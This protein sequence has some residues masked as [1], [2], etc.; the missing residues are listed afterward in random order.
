MKKDEGKIDGKPAPC[1]ILIVDDEET[2][3][4][5]MKSL[6]ERKGFEVL[7]APTGEQALY[8]LDRLKFDL[9]L[10]DLVLGGIDGLSVLAYSKKVSQDTEVVVITGYASVDSAIQATRKGAFHYLQKPIRSDEL[11]HIVE[12]ALE[13]SRLKTR[14][15]E[16]EQEGAFHSPDI[17]GNS[18]KIQAIKS[19]IDRMKQSEANVLIVGESGTGKELIA[20]AIHNHSRRRD[21][22]FL[23][24]NCAS[25]ADELLANELFGHEKDAYTGASKTTPGLLESAD[26]GTVFFDEVGDMSPTM[27]AKILRVV[28]EKEL[29][30]V[31]SSSPIPVDIRI[32][33]ATNKDLKKLVEAGIFRQD[34]YFR[35]NVIAIQLPTLEQRKE[36]IPLLGM[37]CLKKA[38]GR[39][40]KHFDGFSEEAMGLLMNYSFPGN[41]REL[42]NIVERAAALAP[43]SRIEA[44][45]LPSDLRAFETVAFRKEKGMMKT[46]SEIQQD[47]IQWVLS[48]VG[49]NKTHAAKIL[50]IDRVSLYRKL[51]QQE[52]EE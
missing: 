23:A 17:I 15:R 22:R 9:V 5:R 14:V 28:Q 33:S 20:R 42:E 34:L 11:Y 31:G 19:T 52:F 44:R 45:D 29:F 8:L 37:N 50:G 18:P 12:Q 46:L 25:F 39:M 13:R 16:L 27:Q 1:R 49:H 36:D 32:L 4:D 41:I 38:A 40:E 3:L 7:T 2:A 24:F 10:T 51:K 21:R 30:R 26:G 35:L 47:Y 6:M 48:R 43:G